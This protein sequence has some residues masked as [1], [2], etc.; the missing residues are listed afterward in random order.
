[1]IITP[2]SLETNVAATVP[3]ISS[4]VMF[5]IFSSLLFNA[6]VAS[7]SSLC[8]PA[9]PIVPAPTNF[10]VSPVFTQ[11]TTKLTEFCDQLENETNAPERPI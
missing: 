8:Y 10:T 2:S 7:G 6:A 11:A 1:M 4:A 9:E 5:F 3:F